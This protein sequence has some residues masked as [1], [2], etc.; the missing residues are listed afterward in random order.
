MSN[1][2]TSIQKSTT[3]KVDPCLYQHTTQSLDHDKTSPNDIYIRSAR[4]TAAVAKRIKYLFFDANATQV[5]IHAAGKNIPLA[6]RF[7]LEFS[8][9]Y[10]PFFSTTTT[11]STQVV[12][13]HYTP[14]IAQAQ[15]PAACPM[16]S[17]KKTT[18]SD[19]IDDEND[20]E[21]DDEDITTFN[22]DHMMNH[23]LPNALQFS[24]C[25]T[26][27]ER[28]Q[29]DTHLPNGVF[30]DL[31]DE[32]KHDGASAT[33]VLFQDNKKKRK[34]DGTDAVVEDEDNTAQVTTMKNQ[35][36]KTSTKPLKKK[37]V[38]QQQQPTVPATT[39]TTTI[40]AS[41]ADLTS[42]PPNDTNVLVQLSQVRYV[43]EENKT[44]FANGDVAEGRVLEN[45]Q[46]MSIT[47]LQDK[48]GKLLP[49]SR[50]RF[51]STI[52]ITLHKTT[53]GDKFVM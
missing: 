46:S 1:S 5:H 41:T 15:L 24:T 31:G 42:T 25:D 12:T 8:Q 27:L 52:H 20:N 22:L 28:L 11:T 10:F 40:T 2:P 18:K 33:N 6:I 19:N 7:A 30:L 29:H 47:K 45:G 32:Q 34:Q 44:Y 13:D 4:C 3:P 38:E 53:Y 48:Y 21:V 35:G 17:A 51:V 37:K 50:Q 14:L 36:S 39:T 43:V 23:L 9:D 16:Q 49:M 26:T